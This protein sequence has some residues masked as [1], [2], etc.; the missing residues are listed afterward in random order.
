MIKSVL[1]EISIMILLCA[2][3]VLVFGITFYDYIPLTKVIPNK[4]SY[5]VPENI[6]AELEINIETE[7]I[8]TQTITYSVDSDD[9]SQFKTSGRLEEGKA[10]PFSTYVE[11]N[12]NSTIVEGNTTS[13]TNGSSGTNSIGTYYPNSGTK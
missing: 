11:T 5:E 6:K 8:T 4:V 1:K 12:N 13:S 9:L 3:I 10:N 7:A 2:C